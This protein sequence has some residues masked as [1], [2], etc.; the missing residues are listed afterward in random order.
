MNPWSTSIVLT[1]LFACVPTLR[2]Q[3][4][5]SAAIVIRH[6]PSMLTLDTGLLN[7]LVHSEARLVP[8]RKLPGLEAW[9]VRPNVF[10]RNPKDSDQPP[11][12]FVA[13]LT[14][15]FAGKDGTTELDPRVMEQALT[16]LADSLSSALRDRLETEPLRSLREQSS[17]LQARLK[18]IAAKRRSA[19][20]A[21]NREADLRKVQDSIDD[22]QRNIAQ[23]HADLAAE[24]AAR[25][26]L[27]QEL[28]VTQKAL[29][30]HPDDQALRA[31]IAM[32]SNQT[33]QCTTQIQGL[34]AQLKSMFGEASVLNDRVAALRKQAA[35]ADTGADMRLLDAEFDRVAAALA[36][37]ED[38]IAGFRPFEFEIWR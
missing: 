38:R 1:A 34:E 36:R 2:A 5:V 12:V 18:D 10:S 23:K 7:S 15:D 4:R 8:I 9:D 33:L 19:G 35:E 28:Q 27:E 26:A 17:T 11:G 37:V 29:A 24:I 6:D 25:D 16:T 3:N 22:R 14:I 31:R 13:H 32:I 30:E 20:V 21:D